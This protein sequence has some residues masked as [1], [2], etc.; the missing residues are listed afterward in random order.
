MATHLDLAVAN[1]MFSSSV[2]T[3]R[4]CWGEATGPFKPGSCAVGSTPVSIAAGDFNG[5]GRMD[6]AT[7]NSL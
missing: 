4:F 3:V 6:V 5:D 1:E 2:G 7:T